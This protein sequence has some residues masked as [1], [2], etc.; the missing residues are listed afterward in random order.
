[1]SCDNRCATIELN[2]HSRALQACL[3]S[4]YRAANGHGVQNDRESCLEGDRED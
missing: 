2:N 3:P 4:S 1:M